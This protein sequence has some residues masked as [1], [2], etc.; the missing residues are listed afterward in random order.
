MAKKD[1]A[2][3]I[4]EVSEAQ[5]AAVMESNDQG[6][7]V[8]ADEAWLNGTKIKVGDEPDVITYRRFRVS[9]PYYSIPVDCAAVDESEAVAKFRD[10]YGVKDRLRDAPSVEPLDGSV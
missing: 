4:E 5:A 2:P 8:I 10:Y 7:A 6:A 3:P 9:H 1:K